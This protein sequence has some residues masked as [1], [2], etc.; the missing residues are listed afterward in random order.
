MPETSL[1]PILHIRATSH[2][3]GSL[4]WFTVYGMG[5]CFIA[6]RN[7]SGFNWGFV[8][9][10][11]YHEEHFLPNK[12]ARSNEFP[13]LEDA[14]LAIDRSYSSDVNLSFA[15]FR[16]DGKSEWIHLVHHFESE[17]KRKPKILGVCEQYGKY[18]REIWHELDLSGEMI[19]E[20]QMMDSIFGRAR[21]FGKIYRVGLLYQALR[22]SGFE[23]SSSRKLLSVEYVLNESENF[24]FANIEDAVV[25]QCREEVGLPIGVRMPGYDWFTLIEENADDGAWSVELTQA[26]STKLKKYLESV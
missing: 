9:H 1:R 17:D 12:D 6:V 7:V 14:V 13:S 18:H 23:E 25:R 19:L 24:R 2:R 22:I 26:V 11:E 16:G 21:R 3:G 15:S 20:L 5:S 8:Q 10:G 4:G